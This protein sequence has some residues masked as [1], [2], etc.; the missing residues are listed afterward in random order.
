MSN[1]NFIL[2]DHDLTTYED[3]QDDE[4]IKLLQRSLPFVIKNGVANST[5]N[6]Y[7]SAWEKWLRWSSSKKLTGRPADPYYLAIYLNHLL[8]VNKNKGCLT[9]AFYGVRWGH[10]VVGLTSPTE[11]H[12][13]KL[14]Y[15]GALRMCAGVS[16]KKDPMSVETIKDVV[17][18]YCKENSSLMDRRFATVCILGFAGFLRIDELLS[19]QLKNV[20]FFQEY[21]Q[22][23]LPHAKTDQHR[24]GNKIIIA[25]THTQFCPVEHVKS[26][27]KD[28]KL[29]PQE[30][31]EAFLVPRLHKTKKS[32]NA[33][34]T[35]GVSYTS[36]REIFRDNLE[37]IK[38]GDENFGLHSLRSGG[39]SSAADHGVSDRLIS[40]H[41]RWVSEKARNGYL[42]DNIKTRMSVSLSLGL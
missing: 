15:E 10:H 5:F 25:K 29:D 26:F 13:V 27:L 33:S 32:H 19:T 23:F 31:P 39:A 40:K 3:I 35:K 22:I 14:A 34:K 4:E 21:M 38:E 42:K 7:K 11:S 41:G 16:T 1:N 28:A 12:L 24:E 18:K 36:I 8:F 30:N 37:T 17:S 2:G 6:K 9:A 20:S